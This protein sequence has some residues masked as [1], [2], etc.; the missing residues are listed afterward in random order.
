PIE[1]K[2]A[3]VVEH[4][5]ESTSKYLQAL[6]GQAGISAAGVDEGPNRAVG[7]AQRRDDVIGSFDWPL[8]MADCDCMDGRR[9]SATEVGEQID[10]V[11][12]LTEQPAA[13]LF[14]VVQ[15]VVRRQRTG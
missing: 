15:P 14:D 2:A 6:L 9:A 13:A 11:A 10:E 1:L 7:E 5:C 4:G 8:R 3:E 12:A